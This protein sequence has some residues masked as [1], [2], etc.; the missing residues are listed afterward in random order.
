MEGKA[1]FRYLAKQYQERLDGMPNLKPRTKQ[2]YNERLE[3]MLKSW[4]GLNAA[5]VRKLTE[6][7]CR[8]WGNRYA[9]QSSPTNYNNTLFVLRAILAIAV[10][11]GIRYRNPAE[12]LKRVRVRQKVM[13]L[14]SQQQFLKM[15]QEIRRVPFGPGLASAELVEFL[16]YTGLRVKSEAAHVNWADCDFERGEIVVRGA[17]ETGTKNSDPRRVPMI[18][19]CRRLLER[20]RAARPDELPETCVMR[21]RECQ[22]AINRSCKAIGITRFTHHDLR[23]LFA[24]RCIE[25]AVDIPTVSRWL[26]HKDGG[27]LAM[28]VY[29]HLRDSHSVNMAQKVTFSEK[30]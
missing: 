11:Q 7:D 10:E 29:G 23:H 19:D 30:N 14:P 3:A 22:G 24:T 20:L 5:D 21:V 27:A 26:G 12:N 17:P 2:Y 28:K 9:K 4:P 15:V 16:A 8:Q 1:L 13:T 6:D 18:P 25:S